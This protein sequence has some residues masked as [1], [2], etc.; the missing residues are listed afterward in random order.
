M[1]NKWLDLRNSL[2]VAKK[3]AVFTAN[4]MVTKQPTKQPDNQTKVLE[5]KSEPHLR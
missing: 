5:D 2:Y 3:L 4:A 1:A